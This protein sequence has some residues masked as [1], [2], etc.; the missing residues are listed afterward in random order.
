MAG[1]SLKSREG[2][3]DFHR[4]IYASDEAGRLWVN[5]TGRQGSGILSSMVAANCL[6]EISAE[7]ATVDVG[8]PVTIQPFGDLT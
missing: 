2:R 4:G 7:C 8:A 5:T 3:V 6:I 1:E